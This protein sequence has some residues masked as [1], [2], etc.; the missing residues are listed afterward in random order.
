MEN[1]LN[2][3][4]KETVRDLLITFP[5]CRDDD[6][7]LLANIWYEEAK[8]L[9]LE[10]THQFLEA[11]INKKLSNPETIRRCRQKIQEEIPSTRGNNY[12]YRKTRGEHIRKNIVKTKAKLDIR[13]IFFNLAE[14]DVIKNKSVK[15][16]LF[17]YLTSSQFPILIN[18][19]ILKNKKT[20]L[21]FI[22]NKLFYVFF[23]EKE[24]KYEFYKLKQ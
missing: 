8:E 7:I 1:L 12:I 21:L 6:S 13:N 4:V 18:K 3:S 17:N 10:R 24:S 19:L 23:D 9:K 15:I 14:I 22:N 5:K 11:L 20:S 16:D 2:Q